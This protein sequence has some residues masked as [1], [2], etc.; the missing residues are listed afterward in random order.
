VSTKYSAAEIDANPPDALT[1]IE[2]VT[3][4]Q[5]ISSSYEFSESLIS[6]EFDPIKRFE[7]SEDSTQ[8]ALELLIVPIFTLFTKTPIALASPFVLKRILIV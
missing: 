6:I 1:G 8:E 5:S 7:F 3:S 4:S 2:R